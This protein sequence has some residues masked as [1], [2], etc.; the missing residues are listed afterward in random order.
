MALD[1]EFDEEELGE[2]EGKEMTFIDHLEELRWHIIRSLAAILVFTIAAWIYRDFIF[3]DIVLGPSKSTFWTNRV[4]CKVAD[5]THIDGLCFTQANFILQSRE[6]SGQFMMA[7]TQSVIVGLLFAFPYFFW[8][9]WRFIR[10]G[11]KTTEKKA[12]RGAVFWV[13]LLFFMG[14][15]FGYFVVAPMA[16]NFLA[17]FKLDESIQNQFD[18][19]DYIS[20]LSMLTLAC[21]LTFQLPMISF[22]LSQVG[23]LTPGFMREYRKHALIVIL[24]VAAIITPSPDVISQLLVAT[25]LFG[26]YEISIWVSASVNRRKEKELL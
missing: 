15:F 4:L 6:V 5:L 2:T 26:L 25:P 1:Q 24:I 21:G 18:I 22:V 23:I 3:G 10:P 12:A 9:I 14:V 19:N 11:L 8:E 20:L 7:M 13:S 17:N 16:I